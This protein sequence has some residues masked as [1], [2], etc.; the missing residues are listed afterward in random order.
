M[1]HLAENGAQAGFMP[2]ASGKTATFPTVGHVEAVEKSRPYGEPVSTL[3]ELEALDSDEMVM[4]YLDGFG[5]E[6]EPMGNRSKSYW[7]GWRNGARDR[8]VLPHD[9]ASA[10]LAHEVVSSRRSPRPVPHEGDAL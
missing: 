1:K 10:K 3:A 7:H 4:G 5:G 9:A 6:P 8:G 2:I